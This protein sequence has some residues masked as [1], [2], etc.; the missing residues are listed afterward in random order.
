VGRQV[1]ILLKPGTL[2]ADQVKVQPENHEGTVTS[3]DISTSTLVVDLGGGQSETVLV[4]PGAIILNSKGDGQSL[5][6]FGDI[7]ATDSI[8]YFGLIGCGTDA[9]FHA[10]VVVI[11]DTN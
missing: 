9:T 7:K 11:G 10:F 8:A 6:S 2:T 4:E 1:S 5:G 3:T